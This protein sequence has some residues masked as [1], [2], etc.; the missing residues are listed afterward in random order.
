M[1]MPDQKIVEQ[2]REKYPVGTVVVLDHMVDAQAPKPGTLGCVTCVDDTG[3]VFASWL[4]GG[5]L[6]VVYGEDHCHKASA[7]DAARYRLTRL[8][9]TQKDGDRCPRCGAVMP[10]KLSRH[11]L[12]RSLDIMICDE[13]GTEEAILAFK[14]TPVPLTEWTAVEEDW[15]WER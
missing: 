7:E 11:A 13:C 8:A 2:I 6:G 14:G 3:T 1:K 4:T 9:K 10:G 15:P 12:S 5:S